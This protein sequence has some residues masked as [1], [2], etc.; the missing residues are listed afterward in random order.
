[1]LD[2]NA[3]REAQSEHSSDVF[4]V[5]LT[6]LATTPPVRIVNNTE[7]ITSRG[8]EFIACPF[9]IA[10]PDSSDY[11][12][13]DAQIQIDN[14][15]VRIWAAARQVDDAP[16]VLLEVILAS[17][18]DEVLLATTGL[19]LREASATHAVISGKLLA[20]TVWHAGF[21][22]HDYDPLQNPGIFGT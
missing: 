19:K 20:E 9:A 16:E 13:N 21:P 18:P 1:M 14:V 11:T 8:E 3:I 12:I 4:L 22:A 2:R 15:D 6:I 7:N 5:L 10:F 17:D